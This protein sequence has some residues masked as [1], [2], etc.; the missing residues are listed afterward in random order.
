ML[1]WPSATR[2]TENVPAAPLPNSATNVAM[3][4]LVTGLARRSLLVGGVAQ[5]RAKRHRPVLDHGG[6]RRAVT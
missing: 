3:S 1:A 5:R 2:D 6:E 4:S